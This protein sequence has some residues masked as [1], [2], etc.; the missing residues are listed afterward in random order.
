[1]LLPHPWKNEGQVIKKGNGPHQIPLAETTELFDKSKRKEFYKC[2]ELFSQCS[3]HALCLEDAPQ[4]LINQG[5]NKGRPVRML[6]SGKYF[7]RM[8]SR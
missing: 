2:K 4:D 3:T 1:M 7:I 8:A 5:M 6:L